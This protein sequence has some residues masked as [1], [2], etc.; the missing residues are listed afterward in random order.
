MSDSKK[1]FFNTISSVISQVIVLVS[2]FVVPKFI[3]LHYGTNMNG[4]VTSITQFVSYL[5][6]VEAGL[7]GAAI[8][9]LYKPLAEKD[10]SLINRIVSTTKNLYYQVGFYLL[11]LIIV[12]AYVYPKIVSITILESFSVSVLIIILGLKGVIDFFSLAKYRTLLTADQRIYVVL[13]AMSISQLLNMLIIVY[14]AT[15][16]I[17]IIILYSIS[18]APVIVRSM[19][20]SYY[21]NKN[22]SYIDMKLSSEKRL[23][24]N[25]WNVLYLNIAQ[26]AQGAAPTIIITFLLGLTQVSVYSIYNIVFTGINLLFG[27]VSSS[28]QATFGNLFVSNR[29]Q[30]LTELFGIYEYL[31]TQLIAIVYGVTF[32]MIFPFIYLYLNGVDSEEY[33]KIYIGVLF[34]LNGLLY[35]VK[36]PKN[37]LIFAAGH[38][39][40][41]R[42]QTTIQTALLI[43]IGPILVIYFGLY[44]LLLAMIIANLY[45]VIDVTVYVPK[46]ILNSSLKE[47][48]TNLLLMSVTF[49]GGICFYFSYS[50]NILLIESWKEWIILSSVFFILLSLISII[51]TLIFKR[52]IIKKIYSKGIQVIKNKRSE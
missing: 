38:Y 2:G 4:L 15:Q 6:I 14:F 7:G 16:K 43:I 46:K 28:L 35:N 47:S 41:T 10:Y 9:A 26:S 29:K 27:M 33:L 1:V 30:E 50:K 3:L 24:N 19:I 20:L 40:E 48:L 13:N 5:T 39:K 36:G 52:T 42:V 49:V 32:I 22:Y 25:R 45:R 31:F 23:L 21:V 44:G 12:L 51:I 11:G 8:F 34:T 18:L 17:N 37:M